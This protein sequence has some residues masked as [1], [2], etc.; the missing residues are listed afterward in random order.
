MGQA[1]SLHVCISD[2]IHSSVV[3]TDSYQWSL[4]QLFDASSKWWKSPS[5]FAPMWYS[6]KRPLTAGVLFTPFLAKA[7]PLFLLIRALKTSQELLSWT[8]FLTEEVNLSSFFLKKS[9]KLRGPTYNSSLLNGVDKIGLLSMVLKTSA[10]HVI[11]AWNNPEI[12][13]S[14]GN[15][16][17]STVKRE[18]DRDPVLVH[19][20]QIHTVLKITVQILW[21]Q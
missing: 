6:F 4:G 10:S 3:D 17:G 7:L 2:F 13:I 14:L 21:R 19:I 8:V 12:I 15:P 11:I 9:L 20:F 16:A 18:W 1:V 5:I